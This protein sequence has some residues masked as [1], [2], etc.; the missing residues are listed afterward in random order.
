MTSNRDFNNEEKSI[1]LEFE[2]IRLNGQK[3]RLKMNLNDDFH[4]KINAYCRQKNYE[5][6]EKNLLLK[7]INQKVGNLKKEIENEGERIIINNNKDKKEKQ[8]KRI[9][10]YDFPIKKNKF[11]KTY[12]DAL[13]HMLY[14]REIEHQKNKQKKLNKI[15]DEN[16]KLSNDITFQPQ[17]SKRSRE[18]TKNFN[19]KIKVEDRLIALGKANEIKKLQ[20][21]AE[22]RFNERNN[23]CDNNDSHDISYD[24]IN[25]N[26]KRYLFCPK[27]NEYNLTRNKSE[28]IFSRLYKSAYFR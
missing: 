24:G 28:D 16:S 11:C 7:Q 3:E 25:N 27:I 20:K 10:S 15:K 5:K 17:I 1:D 22:K 13:G 14:Q 26:G 2:I 18:I 6:I 12:G 4:S 9:K 19:N 23:L 21:I 8:L